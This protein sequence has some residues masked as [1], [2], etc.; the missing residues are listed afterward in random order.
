[1]AVLSRTQ[2]GFFSTQKI[3]KIKFSPQ[4]PSKCT[5]QFTEPNAPAQVIGLPPSGKCSDLNDN[6][7]A[8]RFVDLNG[9]GRAEYLWLDTQGATTAFLNLGSTQTGI[10][11][12]QVGWLHS[13]IIAAGIGAPRH[14]V[15]FA[16]INGDSRA[17]YLWVHDDGSVDAW[18]N[19]G[20]PD[21]G[22]NAAKVIWQH[23]GQIASGIGKSG[24]GVRFADLN[25]DGRAEYLWIDEDGAMTA[26]LNLGTTDD[27]AHIGWL[28]QGVV[29]T[30]P[31]EGATRDNIILADVNGDGR[32]DYLSASVWV[33]LRIGA[34]IVCSAVTH[35]GGVVELWLN[36]GGP[37]DGPNAAKVVW[38][39][40]GIIANGVGT[41][42]MGV[43]FADLNGDGRTEY[44]D[45]NYETSAV[46]AWLY[47]CA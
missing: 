7:T 42:G 30:G 40:Q 3:L 8:V 33:A 32:A 34:Y 23:Q 38:Y 19:L 21:N 11:A 28:P 17:D 46:N 15:H 39:H 14:Q 20:G 13:G 31:V 2:F 10:N 12:G 18:L 25:G 9:D 29:A 44:L 24:T 4:A 43:Q 35:T 16:D 1:M 47:G 37:D 6:S 36:G 41:S 27:G 45:V 26:Y 22:P 5:C